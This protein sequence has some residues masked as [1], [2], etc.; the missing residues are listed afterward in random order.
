[1]V[2]PA[3][4][5]VSLPAADGGDA[6]GELNGDLVVPDEA[7]GL[8][9]FAHGSGSSRHSSRNRWVAGELQ[10][11]GLATLLM[12]LLTADEDRLDAR[13]GQL[14]FDIALLTRRVLGV[15]DWLPGQQAV[16][17]LPI[18]LFGAS[19]GAA[20]A[21][22]VA[23]HRPAAVRAVVSRGGRP[24]LASEDLAGVRAPTLLVVGGRD[25]EVLGLNRRA[26]EQLS[27]PQE[28]RVVEGATH[29]FEESGALDTVS[30]AAADW[31]G[32][33]LRASA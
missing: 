20:A 8:V 29:L 18:G 12:D 19:T 22:G 26:A 11:A 4:R 7:A 27:G 28:V 14:R 2:E 31:F 10:R 17:D 1:M 15:L 23:A 33:H 9:V 16:R 5:T 13:T 21:L 25:T 6:A 32:R 3:G 24:D 30:A